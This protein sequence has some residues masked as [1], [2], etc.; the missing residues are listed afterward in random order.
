MKSKPFVLAI[1]AFLMI[2]FTVG[3]SIGDHQESYYSR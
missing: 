2:A 1:A 3:W